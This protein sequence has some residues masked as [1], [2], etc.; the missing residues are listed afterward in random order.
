MPRSGWTFLRNGNATC[1]AST[2]PSKN[3]R[4]AQ[5]TA[6]PM[7]ACR[8]SFW[9]PVEPAVLLARHFAP[10][11]AD[12]DHHREDRRAER[13][14]DVA[15]RQVR[16]EERRDDDREVD[17]DA[18]HRGRPRL[19]LVGLRTLLADGLADLPRAQPA[20]EARA[21][22]D[23]EEERHERGVRGPER[24]V[25]EDA[26]DRHLAEERMEKPRDHRAS[27]PARSSRATT[28]S[29]NGWSTAPI[30][31]AVSCPLPAT[32]T[33]SP[34]RAL[35]RASAIAARRSA[36]ATTRFPA[37]DARKDL[38]DDRIGVFGARVVGRDDDVVGELGRDPSHDGALGPVAVAAAP[39]DDD[40][41]PAAG[42]RERADRPQHA[43]ERRRLVRVV[44]EHRQPAVVLDALEAAGHDGD[45]RER[46][47]DLGGRESERDA[48]GRR[49]EEVLGVRPAEE[50]RDDG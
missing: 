2:R 44:D 16:E 13:D 10:V 41:A 29:S 30:T 20:D 34:L 18:A 21:E 40:D 27:P 47:G 32:R 42:L 11:V 6:T 23:R 17:E 12:A 25:A 8:T 38:V 50:R 26:E 33:T 36:S 22:E 7:T 14:P 5:P 24:D 4:D 39:E 46:R 35:R 45:G 9:R 43:L 3:F 15:V 48:G 31:C 19:R 1:V 49:G 28:R 37:G